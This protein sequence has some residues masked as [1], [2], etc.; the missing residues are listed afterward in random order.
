MSQENAGIVMEIARPPIV[1]CQVV[2]GIQ[3]LTRFQTISSSLPTPQASTVRPPPTPHI[4]PTTSTSRR[5]VAGTTLCGRWMGDR[6]AKSRRIIILREAGHRR[7]RKGLW[8][9]GY[10]CD[11]SN[12]LCKTANSPIIGKLVVLLLLPTTKRRTR[13]KS[14]GGTQPNNTL[15]RPLPPPP[16]HRQ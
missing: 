7:R 12:L 1:A 10:I 11:V 8:V 2:S 15:Q 6:M 5:P 16:W 3:F 9:E 14:C 13:R 4:H